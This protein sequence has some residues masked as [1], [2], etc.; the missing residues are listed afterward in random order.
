MGQSGK[1]ESL[2]AEQAQ[3]SESQNIC[4]QYCFSVKSKTAPYRLLWRKLTPSTTCCCCWYLINYIAKLGKRLGISK[5]R[6]LIMSIN[7]RGF[8]SKEG[9]TKTFLV[10]GQVQ[11]GSWTSPE[12]PITCKGGGCLKEALPRMAD[13][14]ITTALVDQISLTSCYMNFWLETEAG[15]CVFL[16]LRE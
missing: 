13:A 12:G 2:N 11:G 15:F 7:A 14:C 8:G 9:Y 6:V 3:F 4:Y 16:N 5:R 1:R 10:P